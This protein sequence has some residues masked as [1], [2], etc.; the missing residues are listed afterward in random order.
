[1]STT[2]T[3]ISNIIHSSHVSD[4]IKGRL[5]GVG[6][7]YAGKSIALLRRLKFVPVFESPTSFV[8]MKMGG[9]RF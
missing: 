9:G 8:E 4:E 1:M 3:P 6:F 2:Q 5:A 7:I